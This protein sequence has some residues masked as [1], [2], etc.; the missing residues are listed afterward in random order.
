MEQPISTQDMQSY[1][2]PGRKLD[3]LN[4]KTTDRISGDMGSSPIL[5]L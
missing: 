2:R 3:S 4:G 5:V 1:L